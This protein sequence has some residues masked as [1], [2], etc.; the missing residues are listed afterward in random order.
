MS[1]S[2]RMRAGLTKAVSWARRLASFLSNIFLCAILLLAASI[3]LWLIWMLKDWFIKRISP[4]ITGTVGTLVWMYPTSRDWLLSGIR[5]RLDSLATTV[6]ELYSREAPWVTDSDTV[7]PQSFVERLT[8]YIKNALADLASALLTWVTV[9]LGL[10]MAIGLWIAFETQRGRDLNR[11]AKHSHSSA[12]SLLYPLQGDPNSMDGICPAGDNLAWLIE[13][14]QALEQC[15]KTPIIEVSGLA[16][17]SPGHD[18]ASDALNLKVANL[19]TLSVAALLLADTVPDSVQGD[20]TRDDCLCGSSFSS[21][22]L[23]VGDTLT[24]HCDAVRNGSA[25]HH[26]IKHKGH[27]K[28]RYMLWRTFERMHRNRQVNDE[29]SSADGDEDRSA[30]EF[31]NRSVR[32]TILN[33]ACLY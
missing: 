12:L 29:G 1:S 13:F 18:D 21:D 17:I 25:P 15:T 32:I 6:R 19:R 8:L 20:S 26:M 4:L 27:F 33:D 11:I 2:K 31:L 24:A 9:L 10:L 3:V 22:T 7:H 16:S 14:R 30:L 23:A 28:V 5:P